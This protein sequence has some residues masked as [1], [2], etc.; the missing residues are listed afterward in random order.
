MTSH[1]LYAHIYNTHTHTHKLKHTDM[2]THIHTTQE[3]RH[4]IH[5]A[6]YLDDRSILSD[7]SQRRSHLKINPELLSLTKISPPHLNNLK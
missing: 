3:T 2:F 7:L 5:P 6:S 1:T 4:I